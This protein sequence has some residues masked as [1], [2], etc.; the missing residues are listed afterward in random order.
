MQ[1]TGIEFPPLVEGVFLR[2]LNRFEA[3]VEV[4]GVTVRVHVPSP[5]RLTTAVA[6]GMP[7]F[8][9]STPGAGRKLP[10]RLFMTR[11]EGHWVVIDSLVANR[12][13]KQ[14]LNREGL[15]GLSAG[16]IRQWRPEPRWG[17]GRFDFEVIDEEGMRHLIE[18]KSVN[19]AEDGVAR[20]PDAP[21]VRGARHLRELVELQRLG[22]GRGW[23]LFVV[24]REDAEDFAPHRAIDP[25][26]AEALGDAAR[27]GVEVW[28][29]WSDIGPKGMWLKGWT[30]W[31]PG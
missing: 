13:I 6:P 22:A 2:R 25:A 27:A 28:A 1:G 18:V 14:M 30:P 17:H 4:E 5:G 12:M 16:R 15:P 8:L 29:I 23:A 21:T 31:R 19:D 20:F 3:Q 10:Y 7:C 24:L 9:A 11:P 26:F